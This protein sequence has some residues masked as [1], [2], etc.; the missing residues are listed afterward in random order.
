M[1]KRSEFKNVLG[2]LP[3]KI[4]FCF[5][6]LPDEISGSVTEIRVRKDKPVMFYG[7]FGALFAVNPGTVSRLF[8]QNCIFAGEK[9]IEQIIARAS[10][11]SPYSHFDE[12]SN[13]FITL[14]GGHRI[15]I[16]ATAVKNGE[17]FRDIASLNIRLAGSHKRCADFI[18]SEIFKNGLCSFLIAG[19]PGS[20]KTTILRDIAVTLSNNPKYG[21]P[22]L[23][24]ADERFELSMCECAAEL[25]C[26]DVIKGY[27]KERA[28]EIALRSMGS[29]MIITD[30][31][32]FRDVSIVEKMLDCGVFVGVSVHASCIEDLYNKTGIGGLIKEGRFKKT[33]VLAGKNSPGTVKK[34][35]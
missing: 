6:N 2:L 32:S 16:G 13:G 22:R 7:G 1:L 20:G 14:N 15:G 8:S 17:S 3:E 33:V 28:F 19:P 21:Y 26:C 9:D 35:I 10:G 34:I 4:R 29:D 12:M 25:I 23:T 31:L 5:E 30:E 27:S 18:C 11:Y 24:L